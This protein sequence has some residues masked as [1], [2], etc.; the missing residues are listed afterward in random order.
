MYDIM[1]VPNR[2]WKQNCVFSPMRW[3]ET[4]DDDDDA[5][6]IKFGWM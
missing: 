2:L 1:R 5:L 6:Q 3:I 4:Y